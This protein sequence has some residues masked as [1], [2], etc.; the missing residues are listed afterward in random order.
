MH[1]LVKWK[2]TPQE[3]YW[4]AFVD[5]RVPI[6]WE[7]LPA[8]G[9]QLTEICAPRGIDIPLDYF[10]PVPDWLPCPSHE[11][12][13]GDFDLYAFYYR[14]TLHTNSF[15]MENAWLDEAARLDPSSYTIAINAKTGRR[16][17]LATGDEVWV[18]TE[19]GR[20]A[21]GRIRL[22]EGIHPEG[23]GVAACAGHWADGLPVAKG[24]GVRFNDLLEVDWAHSSP[25][26][27]NMDLCAKVRITRA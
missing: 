26:N 9:K 10:E 23:L 3:V 4:R 12:K 2:K 1:G 18:E 20:R 22:T 21:K 13:H 6:Y 19:T 14:D 8:M 16:K 25:A 7:W 5:V 17:G 15:T 27:L 11:C 24:K